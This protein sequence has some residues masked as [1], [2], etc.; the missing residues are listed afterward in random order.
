[1]RPYGERTG[2]AE[3]RLA[4]R[5]WGKKPPRY[6]RGKRKAEEAAERRAPRKRE[7]RRARREIAAEAQR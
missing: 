6:R 7:R 1:M 5:E 4:T 2:K 3:L